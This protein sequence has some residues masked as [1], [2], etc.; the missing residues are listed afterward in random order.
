MAVRLPKHFLKKISVA[1]LN[2]SKVRN[3][4]AIQRLPAREIYLSGT[5]RHRY[6]FAKMASDEDYAAFL[7]KVNQDVSGGASAQ[8]TKKAG[9]TSVNTGV[10][11]SLQKFEAYYTSDADEPF[12]P[13]SL[14]WEGDGIPTAE[15]FSDLIGGKEAQSIGEE[16]FDPRGQYKEVVDAVRKEGRKEVGFF[17]VE[18]GGT[19]SEVWVVSADGKGKLVG[20]KAVAIQS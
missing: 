9:T 1:S 11:S 7:D 20:L 13:V 15:D 4:R 14:K 16:D 2:E 6:D 19:R 10:P 17:R 18:L 3:L 8:S 5:A 12:E